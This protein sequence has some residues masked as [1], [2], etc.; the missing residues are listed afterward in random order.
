MLT[1]IDTSSYQKFLS[2][3]VNDS[4]LKPDDF[5]QEGDYQILVDK[6]D[7]GL[8]IHHDIPEEDLPEIKLME[9]ELSHLE[10]EMDED[11]LDG[12]DLHEYSEQQ[13][14]IDGLDEFD[15]SVN[16]SPEDEEQASFKTTP[17][18]ENDY[19]NFDNYQENG[20]QDNFNQHYGGASSSSGRNDVPHHDQLN[21]EHEYQTENSPQEL[22]RDYDLQVD[23]QRN[24]HQAQSAY[25]PAARGRNQYQLGTPNDAFQRSPST[26]FF[27]PR[28]ESDYQTSKYSGM[29]QMSQS[30]INEVLIEARNECHSLR[31]LNE[32]L[33]LSADD[34][35]QKL[36]LYE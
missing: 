19:H 21:N 32:K 35:R 13:I 2:E 9:E 33:L 12:N 11:E 5:Q 7:E 34:Y 26:P 1:S 14:Q 22:G 20:K 23:T 8:T 3:F 24:D 28:N 17:D 18:E 29:S 27:T 6:L 15:L 4:T 16:D 10:I 25:T 30:T 31:A 36:G